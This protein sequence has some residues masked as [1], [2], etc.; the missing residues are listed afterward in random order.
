M[1]KLKEI[2]IN[3]W[4]HIGHEQQSPELEMVLVLSN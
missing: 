2:T 4:F 3:F 1:C